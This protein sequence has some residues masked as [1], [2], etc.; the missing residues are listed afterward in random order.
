VKEGGM[1][2]RDETTKRGKDPKRRQ[3]W[4]MKQIKYLINRRV[5]ENWAFGEGESTTR[6]RFEVAE[7]RF[8]KILIMPRRRS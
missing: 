1:L 8:S 5:K 4:E 6:S 2:E 7:T 3:R